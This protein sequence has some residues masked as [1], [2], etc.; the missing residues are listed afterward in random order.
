MDAAWRLRVGNFTTS[1][2]SLAVWAVLVRAEIPFALERFDL[3]AEDAAE[4]LPAVAPR[5]RLPVLLVEGL[6]LDEPLAIVE[7]VAEGRPGLWP[8]D[9]R[10]RARA[11]ALAADLLYGFADLEALLP[12]DALGRFARPDR[13]TRLQ[14]RELARLRA[15]LAEELTEG[16]ETARLSGGP[17]VESFALPWAWRLAT[18]ELLAAEEEAV[19]ASLAALLERPEAREWWR[20][21]RMERGEAVEEEVASAVPPAP[22]STPVATTEPAAE[23][24]PAAA[25]G[26]RRGGGGLFRRRPRSPAPPSGGV[27][28][29]PVTDTGTGAGEPPPTSLGTPAPPGPVV[30][31]FGPGAARRRGRG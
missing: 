23:T 21:A 4:R 30:K 22:A 7:L 10:A 28:A 6:V 24:R 2:R 1:P 20:L 17:V 5:G 16:E 14:E 19:D 27:E 3:Y 31:P 29:V 26:P 13:L 8:E 11:R 25:A 12:F 18:Y 9:G 15:R